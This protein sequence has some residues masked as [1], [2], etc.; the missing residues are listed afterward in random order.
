[1]LFYGKRELRIFNALIFPVCLS[2]ELCNRP[3]PSSCTIMAV[4]KSR[5]PPKWGSPALGPGK[6][7]WRLYGL[8]QSPGW[9][10]CRE[11]TQSLANNSVAC[12]TLHRVTGRSPGPQ[13][14][15]SPEQPGPCWRRPPHRRHHFPPALAWRTGFHP[16]PPPCGFPPHS[17]PPSC[18]S[19]EK[20][21]ACPELHGLGLRITSSLCPLT[22]VRPARPSMCCHAIFS[23]WFL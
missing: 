8:V 18:L 6:L 13:A 1:M 9:K 11:A 5:Q 14:G 12:Q 4:T 2:S 23:R 22:L 15:C 17:P 19:K 21:V 20:G 10:G 3:V 16:H 7:L